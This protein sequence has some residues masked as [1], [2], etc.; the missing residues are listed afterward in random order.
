MVGNAAVWFITGASKGI[1]LETVRAALETGAR[2]V[3]TSRDPAQLRGQ[4]DAGPD[5]LQAVQMSITDPAQIADAVAGAVDAFGRIDVLVNNAGY[6]VLGAVEDFSRADVRDNFD[7]NVFGLLEV[8]QQVLPHMRRQKAGRVINLASISANV[9]GPATG[10]YSATK[11][12]VLML[13]EALAEEVAPLGVYATAVC[14]G[15][16][17][18]DFL[19]SRSRR[20]AAYRIRDYQNVEAARNEYTRLNHRQGGD[21]RL[22]AE[23]FVSLSQM[24]PPPRRIYLGADALRAV[25]HKLDAVSADIERYRQLSLSIND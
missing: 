1:G 15:G 14:P 16:V 5:V 2:V 4:V 24:E 3:C 22:V 23:A 7:V 10:L 25:T 13:T 17:R 18:T 12:A 6:S 21:P 19:D 9:T 8:T 11:A 20:D